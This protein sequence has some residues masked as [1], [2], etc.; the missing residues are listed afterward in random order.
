MALKLRK[1]DPSKASLDKIAIFG[2]AASGK[3][4]LIRD[5]MFHLKDVPR[6]VIVSPTEPASRNYAGVIPDRFIHD[7]YDPDLI[8]RFCRF[9]SSI[10]RDPPSTDKRS[11]VVLDNCLHESGQ[12]ANEHLRYILFAG[13]SLRAHLIVSMSY[14][15]AISPSLRNQFGYVFLLREPNIANQRRLYEM[16]GHMFPTFDMFS[17]VL[18]VCT[19]DHGCLVIDQ[20]TRSTKLEDQVFWY[21]ADSHPGLRVSTLE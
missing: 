1:F 20:T 7:E 4:T 2:K 16:Y 21:R 11:L 3:T 9:Q 12:F 18:A 8:S 5:L 6:A 10:A 17:Q 14:P 19:E 15:L 13:R